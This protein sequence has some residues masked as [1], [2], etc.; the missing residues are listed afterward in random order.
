MKEESICKQE[1][2]NLTYLWWNEKKVLI[3]TK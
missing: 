2:H 1:P 3:Y